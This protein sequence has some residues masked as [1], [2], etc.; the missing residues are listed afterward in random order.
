MLVQWGV[1][2]ADE[3]KVPSF[4]EATKE[5]FPLYAKFGFE[6]VHTEVFD[7]TKYGAEGTETNTIMI[8][9]PSK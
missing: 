2:R 4:L 6:P 5:G 8:R 7:L 3:A 9:Q 1:K